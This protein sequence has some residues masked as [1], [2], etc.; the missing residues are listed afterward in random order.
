METNVNKNKS[1]HCG[2]QIEVFKCTLVVVAVSAAAASFAS[3]SLA[4]LS[5]LSCLFRALWKEQEV[6]IAR[7]RRLPPHTLAASMG[8]PELE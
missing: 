3:F 2:A 1:L 8:A 5:A 6:K 7:D 4:F